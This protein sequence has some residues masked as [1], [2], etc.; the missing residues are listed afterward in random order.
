MDHRYIDEFSVAERYVEHA[1]RPEERIA[2]EAHLV[3]CQECTDRFLLAGMFHIRETNGVPKPVDQPPEPPPVPTPPLRTGLVVRFSL[4][5]AIL[6]CMIAVL[7]LMAI[8]T[9]L[10]PVWKLFSK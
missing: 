9:I 8:P 3:D 1:L 7:L 5:Q 10:I 2:F 6:L 4:R